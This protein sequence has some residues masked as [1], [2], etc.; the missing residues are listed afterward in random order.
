MKTAE[1]IQQWLSDYMPAGPET[2]YEQGL[3]DMADWI[4][5]HGAEPV[6]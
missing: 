1:Q 5:G 3:Q 6:V 4:L 2:Q